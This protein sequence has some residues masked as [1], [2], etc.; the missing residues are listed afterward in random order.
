[1]HLNPVEVDGKTAVITGTASDSDGQV[2]TVTI[3]INGTEY[4]VVLNGSEFIITLTDLDAGSYHVVAVATDN[5]QQQGS[6][7]VDFEIEEIVKVAPK[8][9]VSAT[10][11]GTSATISGSATD[12]DGEV[13]S[14]VIAVN[15][16]EYSVSGGNYSKT[17]TELAA[18]SYDVTVTAT[19]NDGLTATANTSFTIEEEVV[20]DN[21]WGSWWSWWMDLWGM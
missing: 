17:L 18:G 19:D 13:V 9:T 15:G 11:D 10:V 3:S 2:A 12:E 4:P 14:V 21:P 7:T 5:D 6:D 20:V 1:M 16:T 8:V